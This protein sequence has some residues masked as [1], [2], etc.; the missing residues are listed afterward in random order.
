MSFPLIQPFEKR[1]LAEVLNIPLL[2]LV[3]RRRPFQQLE[4]VRQYAQELG[5]SAILIEDDYVDRDY[6]QDH[7]VFYS[8]SFAQYTALCR[9]IHF[10]KDIAAKEL[11]QVLTAVASERQKSADAYSSACREFSESKYL[12]FSVIK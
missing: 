12:G 5:C 2:P 10:F 11:P 7:S 9:R 8:T 1:S 3:A 4:Y 6:T